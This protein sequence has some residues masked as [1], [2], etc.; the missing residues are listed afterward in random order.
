M[1]RSIWFIGF[2]QLIKKPA[3]KTWQVNL[4][5]AFGCGLLGFPA[6]A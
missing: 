6:I 3:L 5:S 2:D 1:Q 4:K